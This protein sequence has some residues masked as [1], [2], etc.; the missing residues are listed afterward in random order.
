MSAYSVT[1]HGI[2]TN[3][4]KNE[5]KYRYKCATKGKKKLLS[6]IIIHMN[7]HIGPKKTHLRI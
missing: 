7:I 3:P 6:S 1:I 2:S 5:D 4:V